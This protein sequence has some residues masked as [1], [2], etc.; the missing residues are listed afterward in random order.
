MSTASGYRIIAAVAVF[1]AVSGCD[2]SVDGDGSN[3]VNGSVHIAAGKA[4]E[5]ARTVNGSIHVDD[6]A[7]VNSAGTVNGSV[8]LGAH[9]TASSAKTVNGSITL[10]DSAHVT[11]A[12][13]SING[14]LTLANNSEVASSLTNVNGKINL[15]AA[16]VGG[17]IKTVNGNITITGASHV[18]GGIL[19]Q[20]PSGISFNREDPVIVIGPGAVVQG[21]LRFER[22][23]KLYVSDK[24]TIGTVT[25]A[26]PVTFSGDNPPN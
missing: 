22:S 1:L 2:I 3:K 15:T 5:D 10:G 24:A 21:E 26:T 7:T 18:E 20:K 12:A 17:G 11:G 19:V 25:G 23:V 8:H 14:D 16:H 6:N 4:A 9:S 13:G